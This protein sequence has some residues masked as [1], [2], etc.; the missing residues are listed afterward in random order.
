M[1][2]IVHIFVF[3][4]SIIGLSSCKFFKYEYSDDHDV[5]DKLL[6]DLLTYCNNN[7]FENAKKL[8]APKIYNIETFDED[9]NSLINYYKGDL[10]QIKG[11]VDTGQYANWDYEEEH[12]GI[13]YNMITSVDTYRFSVFYV[14]K[15]TRSN[16]NVGINQLFV[17]K[18]SQDDYPEKIYGGDAT[19]QKGNG[20]YV[21]YPHI[22]LEE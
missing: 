2:K 12:H 16:D 6:T 18:L 14:E 13:R 9:L 4:I 19:G 7:D 22:L 8:F 15:D 10:L 21:A 20:I 11:M 5:C 17:L 1:K 3:I